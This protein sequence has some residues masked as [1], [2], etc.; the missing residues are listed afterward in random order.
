MLALE[1]LRGRVTEDRWQK[2]FE[3]NPTY[4]DDVKWL[5]GVSTKLG[6]LQLFSSFEAVCS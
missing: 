4:G 6:K 1:G 3:R 2:K 5:L